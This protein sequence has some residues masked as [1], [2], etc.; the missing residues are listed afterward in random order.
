MIASML[1]I[2]LDGASSVVSLPD[3]VGVLH[4]D[5]PLRH[6]MKYTTTPVSVPIDS[7]NGAAVGSASPYSVWVSPWHSSYDDN[8]DP[9][10]RDVLGR[11]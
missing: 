5:M 9:S 10:G 2:D 6:S 8:A 3:E 11:H 4:S 1:G 7:Y